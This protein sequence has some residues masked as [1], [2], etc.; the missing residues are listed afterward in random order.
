MRAKPLPAPPDDLDAV[1]EARRAVPLVPGSE[2]DCCARLMDRA[3]VP[4]R[5]EAA[6]WLAFL[7]GLGLAEE[8][9]SGFSRTREGPDT[10]DLPAAFLEGVFGAREA[11]SA[12]SV[13]EP[14]DAEAVFEAVEESVPNWERRRRHDWR[15]AWRSRTEDLLDWLAL[16]GLAERVEGGYRRSR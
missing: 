14:R 7:R 1:F 15:E 6:T 13:S 2:E 16:L 12:L 8:G 4:A 3:G 10:D 9:P 11:L 5:D